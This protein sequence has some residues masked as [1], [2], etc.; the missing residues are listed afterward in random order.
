MA[1]GQHSR[2][3]PRTPD[4]RNAPRDPD[5]GPRSAEP[6]PSGPDRPARPSSRPTAST[7]AGTPG[8][9]AAAA[10]ATGSVRQEPEYLLVGTGCLAGHDRGRELEGPVGLLPSRRLSRMGFGLVLWC[11]A[12]AAFLD[13][14]WFG[15][16]VN[17]TILWL[18]YSAVVQRRAGHRGR[19]WRTR[20]WRHAWGGLVPGVRVGGRR[21]ASR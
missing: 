15:L 2:S 17:V 3:M 16:A 19:C 13:A 12:G 11:I 14:R 6:A 5:P 4:P 21:R 20:A 9:S 18:A 8:R 7:R 1:K 10:P